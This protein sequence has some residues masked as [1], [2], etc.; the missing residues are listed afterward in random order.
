M[1]ESTPGDTDDEDSHIQPGQSEMDVQQQIQQ[2]YGTLP[3]SSFVGKLTE[4]LTSDEISDIRRDLYDL[5]LERIPDTPSGTLMVRKDT[6]NSGGKPAVDKLADDVYI[7]YHFHQG[8][9]GMD[10]SKLLTE[11]SRRNLQNRHTSMY[12][13]HDV[14]GDEELTLSCHKARRQ[15]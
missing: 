5:A 8:D 7:L 4:E 10:I 13:P 11:R 3:R 2:R 14:D 12:Q 6:Q 9:K 1:D 15:W